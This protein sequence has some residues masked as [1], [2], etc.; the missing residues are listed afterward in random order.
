MSETELTLHQ[1]QSISGGDSNTNWK[2]ASYNLKELSNSG[3]LVSFNPVIPDPMYF[4]RY[5][6]D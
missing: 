6:T 4:P 3:G 2:K 1:L 5:W